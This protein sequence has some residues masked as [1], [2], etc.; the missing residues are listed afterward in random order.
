MSSSASGPPLFTIVAFWAFVVG[1]L[2][3]G[4]IFV[5]NWRVLNA[6]TTV[7]RQVGAPPPV[8]TL[9]AG[10][11]N[12]VVPVTVNPPVTLPQPT[13]APEGAKAAQPQIPNNLAAVVKT[14]L[15]DWQGT[16][17]VNILLMGIDKR[18]DESIDGTRSDT[19]IL[20]SIDPVAKSAA[21]VSLPRDMWVSIPGCGPRAG[22]IGGM[23]RLNVAHAVGGPDLVVQTVSRDFSIPI[24]YYARVDFRGFQQMVDAVDGVVIDVDWPVKDDEYPT[25][26]YGYQRIYF[27]PGPQLMSGEQALEYARSRHGTSDFARAGRQQKVIVSVRNRVLQLDMLT[28]APELLGIAQK[29]LATNLQPVQMLALAKLVSQIDRER[30]NNLVID[31]NYVRPFVGADG[32][33]LLDPNIPAIRRAIAGAQKTA[34]HPEL[35]AKV[36][37]LNGSGTAGL[38]QKA[39]DLLTAQGFNVVRI[40]AAER[41]DY[42]SSL[43]QVLGVDNDGAAQAV[44]NVLKM[45]ETAIVSGEPTPDVTADIRIVVGQDFRLPTSS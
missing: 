25:P 26:D 16:E 19:M 2:V 1:G 43:V 27:G 36:E 38:G 21:M 28:R 7:A 10:P 8:V 33:D 15:P 29:S 41:S 6:R 14:V 24:Q 31:G 4:G 35:R 37:V 5:G 11:V 40:A 39:A 13:A 22:C 17:P 3:F 44:A 34:A 20:A 30:I 12:V 23:Q 42:R 9:A 32:A 18:D 45:P